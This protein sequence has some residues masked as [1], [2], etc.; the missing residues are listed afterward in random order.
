MVNRPRIRP[1]RRLAI[2]AGATFRVFGQSVN[3]ADK[4]QRSVDSS[5]AESWN[6]ADGIVTM[7]A[8]C[9]Y[10]GT[11]SGGALVVVDTGCW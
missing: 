4:R 2:G 10:G 1:R 11:D 9:P 8:H 5:T 6:V 3:L 7:R